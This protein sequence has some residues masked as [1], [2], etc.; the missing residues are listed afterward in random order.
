MSEAPDGQPLKFSS[1]F[2]QDSR[3]VLYTCDTLAAMFA[4]ISRPLSGV[5]IDVGTGNG[6]FLDACL[7]HVE[8]RSD[9]AAVG[10]DP[11]SETRKPAG[12]RLFLAA[13]GASLPLPDASISLAL[14]HFV[15]SRVP[16][17]VARRI[18]DEVARVLVPGGTFLVVE[19]CLGMSTYHT[20]ADQETGKMMAIAR[21]MKAEFQREAHDVDENFGLRLPRALGTILKV[22][23]VDLHIARWF[24][25][26]P[27]TLSPDEAKIV[28]VRAESLARNATFGDFVNAHGVD[29]PAGDEDA[30]GIVRAG[31]KLELTERGFRTLSETRS[32]QLLRS[33]DSG[34]GELA[35]PVEFIPV[36][37]CLAVKAAR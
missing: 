26:F 9:V 8:H 13:S 10:I 35:A 12:G 4:S 15:L 14:C 19:P 5:V 22:V 7:K 37:R 3:N 30:A 31:P 24:T 6:Y 23:T 2:L 29:C 36:V 1:R 34:P 28:R 20:E 21:R 33:L 32:D 16:T 27:E 18:L 25:P 11:S 17:D